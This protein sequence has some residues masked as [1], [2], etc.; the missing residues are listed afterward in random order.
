MKR[1]FS[2]NPQ[3]VLDWLI[4]GAQFDSERT[5]ELK[6]R[7]LQADKLYNVTVNGLDMIGHFEMQRHR[8]GEMGRRGWEYNAMIT[9]TS[10]VPVIPVVVY[11]TQQRQK[12]EAPIIPKF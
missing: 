9:N 6:S 5:I 2:A 4:P 1:L 8:D 10:G 7:T 11:F 12:L 3:H